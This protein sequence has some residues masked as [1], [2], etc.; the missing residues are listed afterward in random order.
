MLNTFGTLQ[1]IGHGWD[2]AHGQLGVHRGT[3]CCSWGFC[4]T[5]E[6][7]KRNPTSS[8]PQCLDLAYV[9]EIV[10][11]TDCRKRRGSWG[12]GPASHSRT[13]A[14]GLFNFFFFP[15]LFEF[16]LVRFNR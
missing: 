13:L 3:D 9:N 1:H 12:F 7:V 2:P 6:R 15:L 8:P 4:Q 16:C 10:P 14:C 11:A 5:E